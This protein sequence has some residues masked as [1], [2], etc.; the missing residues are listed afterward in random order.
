MFHRADL[1]LAQLNN[2]EDASARP[3]AAINAHVSHVRNPSQPEQA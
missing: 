1:L 2:T 3:P